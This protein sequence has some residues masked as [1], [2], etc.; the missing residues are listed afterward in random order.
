[1]K[2]GLLAKRKRPKNFVIM[3]CNCLLQC[4]E[5]Y[6]ADARK[7]EHSQFWE[8]GSWEAQTTYIVSSVH[9]APKKRSFGEQ[10]KGSF[11]DSSICVTEIQTKYDKRVPVLLPGNRKIESKL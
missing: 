11:L 7:Q 5:K 9:T 3:H 2:V 8:L 10:T 1:M 6:G 4:A